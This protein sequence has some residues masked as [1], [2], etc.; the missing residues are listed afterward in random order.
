MSNILM[1]QFRE[2]MKKEDFGSECEYTPYYRTGIDIFDYINGK[3]DADGGI[4]LGLP[5]GKAYMAIAESGVGKTTKLI[6]QACAIADQFD[7]STIFHYDF[8]R[9][10]SPERVMALT[11]WSKEKFKNKYIHLTKNIYAESLFDG[12]KAIAKIK[13]ENY[14]A[15]KVDTGAT[16]ED[17]NIIYALPPT[18]FLVDSVALI[19]P[20]DIEDSEEMKGSMG[21]AAI[22]KVNT[23]V[24]KRVMS[25]MEDGNI[26]LMLV[27]HLTKKIEIGFAKT[28]AQVNYLKQDD[29]IPGGKAVTYLSNT[30]VKLE[31]SSKLEEDKE[32]GVKGFYMTGILVKSR[33]NAAG[34]TFKMVFE[35]K[36]GINNILTNYVNLKDAKLIG[37][38][39]RSYY[40]HSLP[41]VKFSQKLVV[42]KYNT[43]PEFR[44]AFDKDVAELY[45]KYLN[46]LPESDDGELKLIDSE[47]NVYR[48]GDGDFWYEEDGDYTQVYKDGEDWVEVE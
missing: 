48:D 31:A 6:Q 11:G 16:D 42:E 18:I 44:K 15:L 27:N 24:F 46:E 7:E 34:L 38:A 43:V 22:A 9:A 33:S 5:A 1:G 32:F 13:Q 36:N 17:G 26:I 41:T 37:G 14:E 29:S 47:N 2:A 30:L 3:H 10:T 45:K 40:L 25:P 19:A 28:K 4:S 20:K 23:N 12:V 39:G 35:Q 21:A 8:E